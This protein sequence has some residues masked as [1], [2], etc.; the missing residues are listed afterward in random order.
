M[1]AE[2][3]VLPIK[4]EA[5]NAWIE[6]LTAFKA[7]KEAR[8]LAE[9]RAVAAFGQPAELSLGFS[10]YAAERVEMIG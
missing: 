2:F 3:E 8:Q 4:D 10:P 9:Q 5:I 1:I 6:A 7:Q